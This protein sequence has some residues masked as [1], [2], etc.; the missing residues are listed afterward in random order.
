MT[1]MARPLWVVPA[2]LLAACS[3]GGGGTGASPSGGPTFQNPVLVR[4][5]PDPGVIEVDGTYY[6][7]ATTDGAYRIQVAR[8][9][10]LVEW[11][12]LGDALPQLPRWA[13]GDTWAPEPAQFDDQFV[14]Y[15]SARY[16]AVERP[17]NEGILCLSR[18]VA[19]SPEGPFVDDTTEPF[20]CNEPEL[21]GSIDAFPFTD[22]DGTRY[23]VWKN[24]GNCCGKP[25]EFWAQELSEDG[26]SVTGEMTN[27]GVRNDEQWEGRVIEAPT[28]FVNEGTYY[29]F[30]SANAYSGIEYAV[31]YATAD[32]VLGPYTDAEENPILATPEERGQ[33][34]F[35]PGGQAIVRDDDGEL[36]F[37]YHA[38][39]SSFQERDMWI[40]ELVFEDGRP[41]IVGPDAG[42]QAAP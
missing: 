41:V 6:A 21:G 12:H 14:I 4:D 9:D 16:P 32:N 25:T 34:P 27:L 29:L 24:D 35:G 36:W 5:F 31:G 7:Y 18:A 8:S 23:L 2:L 10:D 11:E 28:I 33:G 1:R 37:V 13:S 40:D 30:F 17:N 19:D 15:Y 3:P 39:R 22:E 38:W 20:A 26:L 42:P